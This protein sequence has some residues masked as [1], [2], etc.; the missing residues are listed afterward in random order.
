MIVIASLSFYYYIPNKILS[1]CPSFYFPE[2][3]SQ[4]HFLLLFAIPPLALA[5]AL[6]GH[7]RDKN[8]QKKNGNEI[9]GKKL[10]HQKKIV[11]GCDHHF[12]FDEQFQV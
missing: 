1:R 9:P 12:F 8:K 2:P 6:Y 4:F 10:N 11:S 5:Q 7:H 3:P